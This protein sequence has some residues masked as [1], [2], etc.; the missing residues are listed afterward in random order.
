MS[1]QLTCFAV[2]LEREVRSGDDLAQLLT[3]RAGLRD[4][5]VVVVTSKVVSKAEGRVVEMPR[6]AAVAAETDR[7][8]AVRGGTS[9]VRTRHGL[10]MAAA[11]VDASNTHPG[12]V[13]L[14]PVDPDRSARRLREDLAA[15]GPN[16]AVLV[17]DTSG[18][19]WRKGQTDIA[20][21]AAGIEV[22][23][24]FVGR[25]D[26]YGNPLAVTAP[27]VA[28]ELTGAAELVTGKLGGAP[29]AVVRGLG[30][31]VLARGSHGPGAA[32]L[33]REEAHDMFG[34][35]AREAVRAA[36]VAPADA[37][38]GFGSAVG[39]DELSEAVRAVHGD[40]DALDRVTVRVVPG[41]ATTVDVHLHCDDES[42]DGAWALGRAELTVRAVATSMGWA[43]EPPEAGPTGG[44]S[45]GLQVRVRLR[46]ATP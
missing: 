43:A 29:F 6:A 34:Y 40:A 20:V 21:G 45:S 25:T 23:D 37:A 4:G 15:A 41:N 18:R 1:R 36:L 33:V 11:G 7:T 35:G 2:P 28:D 30:R 10:V 9:I 22:L 38:R 8:V 13:V 42:L 12:T 31:L 16:V 46:P 39:A 3:A 32:G 5:D 14:L 44:G 27:A 17:A 26:P 24:S 19:A